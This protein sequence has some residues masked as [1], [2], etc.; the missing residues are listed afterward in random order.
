MWKAYGI[1]KKVW[2]AFKGITPRRCHEPMRALSRRL[3]SLLSAGSSFE[4]PICKGR[5]RELWPWGRTKDLVQ[6][7]GCA[8]QDRERAI[9]LFLKKRTDVFRD[10]LKVLH[11]APEWSLSRVLKGLS[12]LDYVSADIAKP[13]AME[14]ID[15]AH[16]PHS[17]C[18]F[19]VIIC[20]HVLEH[21]PDDR[22]AMSE[23]YRV[24][25]PGGWALTTVPIRDDDTTYED[26]AI[27]S[28]EDRLKAFGEA[29]HVRWYG[30]DFKDRLEHVGFFVDLF[31]FG[32]VFSDHEARIHALITR[33]DIYVCSKPNEELAF[34][35]ETALDT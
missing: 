10:N 17:D 25:R 11:L 18:S 9:Y 7:P 21:I 29:S 28:R 4:C 22:K 34:A 14:K 3:V 32:E 2:P 19:H 30:R 35:E 23:M 27:A 5:F 13:F 16:I 31:Q 26:P 8:S 15:I 33:D 12:N 1:L 20:C 6:C 24:L